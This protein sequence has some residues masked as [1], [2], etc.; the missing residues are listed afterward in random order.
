MAIGNTNANQFFWGSQL[1][2]PGLVA[3]IRW[4]WVSITRGGIHSGSTHFQMVLP[5]QGVTMPAII[6]ACGEHRL[7]TICLCSI[8]TLAL[9]ILSIFEG[10]EQFLL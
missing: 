9:A 10:Q 5:W 2:L 3:T 4:Y 8:Q 7:I 1:Y 6:P